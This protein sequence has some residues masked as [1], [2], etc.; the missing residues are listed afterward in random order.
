MRQL[1][2]ERSTARLAAIGA[3][4]VTILVLTGSVSDPVNTPKLFLL[5]SLAFGLL[6]MWTA[7]KENFHGPSLK[8]P[9]TVVVFIFIGWSTVAALKSESPF[10]QNFYGVYGRNTGLLAYTSLAICALV[11]SRLKHLSSVEVITRGFLFAG[12]VNVIYCAWVGI[13]GDFIG[14]NNPYKAILGTFGNPNFISSFLGMFL[15]AASAFFVT[16][17]KR[18][19][20]AYFILAPILIWEL[21]EAN[22]LQGIVVAVVGVWLISSYWLYANFMKK[23]Y[24][25][26]FFAAGLGIGGLG[27]LGVIGKG[28]L[29]AAMAQPTV[30]LREQYWFAAWRMGTNHPIFGVGLDTYGDWYR[31][32]RGEGALI[33]PGPNV[34]TNVA[35]NVYLDFLASG[36]FPLLASYVAITL[37]GGLSIIKVL[38]RR[39]SFNPY[40]GAIAGLWATYHLQSLISI[41]QIGLAIWGWIATGLLVSYSKIKSAELSSNMKAKS[42]KSENSQA[43]SPGIR[44]YVGLVVGALIA[45]PPLSADIKWMTALKAQNVESLEKSLAGNYFTPLSSMRLAQAAQTLERSGLSD[46]AIKYA[47]IGIIHNP[48]YDDAWET[49]YYMKL[50]TTEEKAMARQKLIE[51]DPL[52]GEWK[53]LP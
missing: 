37:I 36:G 26:L 43:F 24:A 41:N 4:L 53:E 27:L 34:V 45:I 19:K 44:G 6:A 17:N 15:T 30:A 21:L 11:L 7:N 23:L 47:R 25:T 32:M 28:P 40:F 16:L 52:N 14:W 38:R 35:H 1:N 3:P 48:N 20:L 31:R 8:S 39:E 49:I 50:A 10:S 46:L 12:I 18:L 5:G 29:L 51:L 9:F 42:V 22:S 13:F 33:N 2:A